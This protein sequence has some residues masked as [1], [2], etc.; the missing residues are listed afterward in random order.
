M[1]TLESYYWD[2]FEFLSL[3]FLY[4]FF[5]LNDACWKIVI[6]FNKIIKMNFLINMNLVNKSNSKH[7]IGIKYIFAIKNTAFLEKRKIIT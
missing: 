5:C 3:L 6:I 1:T 2:L 4:V 7:D